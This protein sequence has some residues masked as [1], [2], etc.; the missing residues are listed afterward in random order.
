MNLNIKRARDRTRLPSQI[1]GP[2]FRT[3]AL[4][5]L[6]LLYLKLVLFPAVLEHHRGGDYDLLITGG[7][8]IDGAGNPSFSADIGIRGDRI[9]AIG[10]L[11]RSRARRTLD[12]SGMVIA[13]GFIDMLGQSEYAVLADGSSFEQA[14]PGD[15]D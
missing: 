9:A 2:R 7:H 15:Y 3:L 10:I 5:C 8:V 1:A 11:D 6:S 4:C 13:P 12:A 14:V